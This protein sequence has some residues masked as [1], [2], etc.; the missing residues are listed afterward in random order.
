ML[1]RHVEVTGTVHDVEFNVCKDVLKLQ[2]QSNQHLGLVPYCFVVNLFHHYN[3]M[4]TGK[5]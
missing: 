5:K 4:T 1:N 3:N 2:G